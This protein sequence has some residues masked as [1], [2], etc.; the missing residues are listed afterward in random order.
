MRGINEIRAIARKPAGLENMVKISRNEYCLKDTGEVLEY[1][2]SD[3]R[4]DSKGGL[5]K[6][7]RDLRHLIN[8]NFVAAENELMLTLTYVE[9]M[10]DPKKLYRDHQ[11]FMQRLR[12]RYPDVEYIL[13]V[14]PQGRGAWHGHELLLFPQ[15]DS[16]FIPDDE[17]AKLWGHGFTT[18]RRLRSVDDVG[19]YYT[20][21]LT[22]I[23]LDEVN[24]LLLDSHGTIMEKEVPG[25]D[26]QTV[27]KKFIKG[28][29]LHMYPPGMNLYRSSRGIRKPQE[30][31]MSY[32][33]T[34]EIAGSR[35]PDYATARNI[36]DD[37]NNLLNTVYYEYYNDRRAKS[38]E[39]NA[40][41][42]C[43]DASIRD[44]GISNR[45]AS[46]GEQPQDLALL[47]PVAGTL[48]ELHRP[49]SP[50]GN[51]PAFVQAVLHPPDGNGDCFNDNADIHP[52]PAGVPDLVLQR[53]VHDRAHPCSVQAPQ[54]PEESH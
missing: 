50:D 35:T 29:R 38:Q 53:G 51:C 19:A 13:T 40:E 31:S 2:H 11:V 43:G 39:K 16:I 10:T 32:M 48:P 49:C 18:T 34:K 41:V 21:Y 1:K 9:N 15:H 12:R 30:L 28:G 6:T 5:A 25:D 36:I 45:P 23:P 44:R 46:E 52:R 24:G 7:F 22:D 42:S 54:G 3:T 27:K 47:P 4:A 37:G 20:A 14:E 33:E 8:N 17:I 26:G